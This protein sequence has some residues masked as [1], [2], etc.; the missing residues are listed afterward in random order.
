MTVRLSNDRIDLEI[1]PRGA[2]LHSF[3]VRQP[4]GSWRNIVLS[5]PDPTSTD[6]SYFGATVGRLANRLGGAWFELDG[7]SHQLLAN[8]GAN[9]LHGGPEG[10]AS[11]N[12]EVVE[13]TADRVVLQLTSPDGDQGYPGTLRVS[14][15]YSLLPDGAQVSYTATTDAPTVVNLTAHPYFVLGDGTIEDHLVTV[16]SSRF[17][18]TD[19]ELIPTGEIRSSEGSAFDLRAGRLISELLAAAGAEGLTRRGAVDQNFVV[20]GE[21]LREHVRLVGPAGTL[22]VR[23]DAPAVQ[24]YSGEHL[25]RS[26]LA[27]EPQGYPDAPNHPEFPSVVLRPGESYATTTQWI[28]G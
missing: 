14:A 10:F 17:T 25:G 23:S 11:R 24:L 3:G 19:D 16:P 12:W 22:V 5:R 27:I 9:Q 1:L 18:P 15:T 6:A 4:D 7:V 2:A 21:G 13:A 26:G 8:E 28:V 20:D